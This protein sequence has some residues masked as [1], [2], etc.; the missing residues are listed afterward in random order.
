MWYKASSVITAIQQCKQLNIQTGSNTPS[1]PKKGN[2]IH[3]HKD[4]PEGE[5][6]EK[7]CS[8]NLLMSSSKGDPSILYFNY[9][10]SQNDREGI[11]KKQN[12]TL[13]MLINKYNIDESIMVSA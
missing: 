4:F 12:S 5:G 11:K 8:Q 13:R 6:K 2:N 1:C 10:F 3:C 9:Y 7:K